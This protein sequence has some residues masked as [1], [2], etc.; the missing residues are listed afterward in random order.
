MVG[1]SKVVEYFIMRDYKDHLRSI[2]EV[3][4]RERGRAT[5]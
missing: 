3:A 2:V 1:H 5:R 4:T